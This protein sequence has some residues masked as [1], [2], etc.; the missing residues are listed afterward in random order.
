MDDPRF[1]PT[2]IA[3]AVQ[4]VSRPHDGAYLIQCNF[5]F[6]WPDSPAPGH[7]VERG[8]SRRRCPIDSAVADPSKAQRSCLSE[9]TIG[10]MPQ[11]ERNWMGQTVAYG[12][13]AGS[14]VAAFWKRV[15]QWGTA[16]SVD[17]VDHP[18]FSPFSFLLRWVFYANA[19][20]SN[21]LRQSSRAPRVEC[22]ET[23]AK[24]SVNRLVGI[25]VVRI[26]YRLRECLQ[27]LHNRQPWFIARTTFILFVFSSEVNA[28]FNLF[29]CFHLSHIQCMTNHTIKRC[30]DSSKN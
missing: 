18:D 2:F 12:C 17:R 10:K 15:E 13:D 7:R 19:H 11:R 6:G 4:F 26:A 8:G 14:P 27:N 3:S 23:S 24:E 9:K 5:S 28:F 21:L 30:T 22:A 16:I 29:V 25:S 20:L 1:F